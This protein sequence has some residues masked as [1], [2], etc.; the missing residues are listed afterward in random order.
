MEQYVPPFLIAVT[1]MGV[2]VCGVGVLVGFLTG[3]E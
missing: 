2:T 1:A 3:R